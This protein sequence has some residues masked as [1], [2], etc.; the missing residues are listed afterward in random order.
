MPAHCGR[1]IGG[2]KIKSLVYEGSPKEGRKRR[3]REQRGGRREGGRGERR[4]ERL[5][6]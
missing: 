5:R 1:I 4:R 3:R 6:V 2:E